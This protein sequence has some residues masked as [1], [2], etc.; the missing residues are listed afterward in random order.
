[1]LDAGGASGPVRTDTADDGC[2]ATFTSTPSVAGLPVSGLDA[3]VTFVLDGNVPAPTSGFGTFAAW[4]PEGDY[5]LVDAEQG[6]ERV[7][8]RPM[9]AMAELCQ[10]PPDGTGCLTTTETMSSV[11]FGLMRDLDL[12][13]D[14]IVLVPAWL[15]T[16]TSTLIDPDGGPAPP[17]DA[18][19]TSVIAVTAIADSALVQPPGEVSTATSEPGGSGDSEP[20]SPGSSGSSDGSDGVSTA[21]PPDTGPADLNVPER[22][23]DMDAPAPTPLD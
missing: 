10:V 20:G 2:A 6:W 11:E 5:P 7:A 4:T 14:R 1:M 9:P 16:V 17:V 23:A 15:F 21:I 12:A 3:S 19:T 22:M 18:T 13:T 8:M